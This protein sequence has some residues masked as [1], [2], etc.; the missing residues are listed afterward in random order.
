LSAYYSDA[1]AEDES[2]TDSKSDTSDMETDEEPPEVAEDSWNPSSIF[3]YHMNRW[4]KHY[5]P[6][7]LSDY[8]RVAYLLCPVPIVIE[9][10]KKNRDQQDDEAVDRLIEK[11]FVPST[12]VDT[13]KRMTLSATLLDKFWSELKLFRNR[14]GVFA[15]EKIW[16]LAQQ[17]NTKA[18]DWHYKYSLGKISLHCYFK[19]MW[20]WRSRASLE[21]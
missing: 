3:R 17:D 11:L 21:V 4:W 16:Y 15:S 2:E 10:A 13:F 20:D 12:E 9:H 18:F 14:Q 8:V 6:K 5:R 19:D 1:S 7:L